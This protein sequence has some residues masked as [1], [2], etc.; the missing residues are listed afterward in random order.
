MMFHGSCGG[1]RVQRLLKLEDLTAEID[2]KA[3][4]SKCPCSVAAQRSVGLLL[5]CMVC[6][7]RRTCRADYLS[8]PCDIRS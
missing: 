7:D 4:S 8:L 3:D 6:L 1:V 5:L 2:K